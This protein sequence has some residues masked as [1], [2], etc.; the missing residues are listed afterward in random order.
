MNK[1]TRAL[2][3]M[4]FA[5]VGCGKESSGEGSVTTSESAIGI[6]ECDSYI[7]KMN[8][9]LDTLPTESRAAREPGFKAMQAAWREA[10]K[11]P[12]GKENLAATCKAQLT[13]IP[14]SAPA[15]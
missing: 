5:T 12:G 11:A 7:E 14:Q 13:T 4:A 9:F 1:S 3:L 2:V 15:K 8:A 6:A 10:A